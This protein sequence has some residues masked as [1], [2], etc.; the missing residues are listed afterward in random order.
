MD[1][2]IVFNDPSVRYKNKLS[3][4]N[5][6]KNSLSINDLDSNT[7]DQDDEDLIYSLPQNS[8]RNSSKMTRSEKM[9]LFLT[10]L[11]SFWNL[12]CYLDQ[13]RSAI[14]MKGVYLEFPQLMLHLIIPAPSVYL[15]YYVLL[16]QFDKIKSYK[17]THEFDKFEQPS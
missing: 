11:V 9:T 15:S 4:S 14:N 6:E 13:M 1:K 7:G 8:I 3:N 16:E 5:N 12:K 17:Y 10:I 2:S